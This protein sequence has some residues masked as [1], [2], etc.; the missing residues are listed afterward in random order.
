MVS[1]ALAL[2]WLPDAN[3]D[4]NALFQLPD[5]NIERPNTEAFKVSI[6]QC[7][8]DIRDVACLPSKEC[9][10]S[11]HSSASKRIATGINVRKLMKGDMK[12]QDRHT[13]PALY[14]KKT[15]WFQPIGKS[16]QYGLINHWKGWARDNSLPK[17]FDSDLDGMMAFKEDEVLEDFEKAALENNVSDL[18]TKEMQDIR[19]FQKVASSSSSYDNTLNLQRV[20]RDDMDADG[21]NEAKQQQDQTADQFLKSISNLLRIEFNLNPRMQEQYKNI[22]TDY[23]AKDGYLK[24]SLHIRRN[25]A[26]HGGTDDKTSKMTEI[27]TTNKR[28]CYSAS[29]YGDALKEIYDKYNMPLDIYLSTDD[30]HDLEAELKKMGDKVS[31]NVGSFLET[32]SSAKYESML[33]QRLRLME[34]IV[35]DIEKEQPQMKSVVS[36]RYL[37]YPR[38]SFN[39]G[40]GNS[41]VEDTPKAMRKFMFESSL[42]DIWHLSHGEVYVGHFS[43]R[44]TKMAYLLAV[45][46]QNNAVPFKSVDGH[47]FCCEVDENCDE[48]IGKMQSM[49]DCAL[50]AHEMAGPCTKDY[51]TQG[52]GNRDHV[53]W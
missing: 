30:F 43:S 41:M 25:D 5:A 36:W 22:V 26:C 2:R 18:V 7:T 49:A 46:R 17:Q 28:K 45:A 39:Y 34:S 13:W 24:V 21:C 12:W 27:F 10:D 53:K 33:N 3:T 48:A 6:D 15:P 35:G 4:G 8:C 47:S 32:E 40:G 52:C 50:F 9:I 16:L 31:A 20:C 11:Y 37:G 44:F 42:Q 29:V 1:S 38:A 51:W 14:D 23:Q 19:L